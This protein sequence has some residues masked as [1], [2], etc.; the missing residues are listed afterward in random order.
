MYEKGLND[1]SFVLFYVVFF[2]WTRDLTMRKLL[3][4]IGIHLSGILHENKVRGRAIALTA[5]SCRGSKNKPM[6]FCITVVARC[7]DC[8]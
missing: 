5:C 7:M 2:T 6:P 3:R 1:I 4:P 8:T